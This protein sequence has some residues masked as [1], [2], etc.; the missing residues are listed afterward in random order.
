MGSHAGL[1]I[2]AMTWRDDPVGR[3][4]HRGQ[5]RQPLLTDTPMSLLATVIGV[6]TACPK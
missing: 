4:G 5:T 3:R 1:S 2:S 6:N